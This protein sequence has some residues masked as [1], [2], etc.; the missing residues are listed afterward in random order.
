[1][2]GKIEETRTRFTGV[3]K[4]A[5]ELKIK[6]GSLSQILHG[7]RVPGKKLVAKMEQLGIDLEKLAVKT[8]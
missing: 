4:T 7:R 5:R 3:N 8:A 1:M 2:I 6:P